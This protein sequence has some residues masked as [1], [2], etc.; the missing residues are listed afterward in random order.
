LPAGVFRGLALVESF[1]SIAAEVVEISAPKDAVKVHRVVCAIDSG[2]V[3]N[4]D[5]VRAQMEGG[6][7]FGLSAILKS[8]ITLD[9]G[10]VVEGNYDTYDVLRISEMPR[11][12]VHIVPSAEAPAGVGEPG[13]PPIGPA[14]ANAYFA[15]TGRRVRALPFNA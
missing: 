8:K 3:I 9:K 2:I 1:G 11:V 7:G 14:V 4:P 10:R 12:E 15:A 5:N 13:V 6:I